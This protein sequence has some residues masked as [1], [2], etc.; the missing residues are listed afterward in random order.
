MKK[1]IS[2]LIA[3][4]VFMSNTVSS[5]ALTDTKI[6]TDSVENIYVG[7]TEGSE[8]INNL[9]YTDVISTHWAREKIIRA[10]A[11]D[12]VKAY[13]RKFYPSG[14]VSNQEAVAFVI[15]VMGLENE[16]QT[17]AVNVENE[18][19]QTA[20]VR[21][22][23][24]I[25]YLSLARQNG[26]IS[27]AEY[28]DCIN[29]NQQNLNPALNF[30]K[31]AAA[32]RERV[33][34][35]IVKGIGVLDPNFLIISNSQQSMYKYSD[36]DA[37]DVKYAQSLEILC[38]KGILNG[39]ANGRI[40]PKGNLTRAEM[41]QILS[42]LDSVYFNSAGFENKTGTVGGIQDSQL[43]QTGQASL[44]RNIYIRNADGKIDVLQYQL[45]SSSSPQAG[46]RDSVVYKNG[47][48][49]GLSSLQEGD[50]IE[51][52]VKKEPESTEGESEPVT[53][54]EIPGKTNT[55]A[56]S[57]AT[58][59]NTGGSADTN[60]PKTLYFVKVTNGLVNSRVQ[61]KLMQIDYE[62]G[63]IH[64]LDSLGKRFIYSI[65][66]GLYGKDD[67]GENYIVMGEKR[68]KDSLLPYGSSV[69]L[70]LVNNVV[71]N[72]EYV[73]DMNLQNE[74][75]GTVVENNQSFGYLTVIDNNGNEVTKNYYSEQIQVEKQQYYDTDDEVGYID[76][77]FP[78][79]KYD[80]RDTVIS[81][82]EP[83]DIVFIKTKLDDPDTIE[84][85]S[86]STNY[87]MKYGKISQF[88]VDGSGTS[89]LMMQ[90][91]NG[92]SA[93]FE[94][95]DSIFIS[96]AG[97]PINVND[98]KVGDWA[99]IL[100]NQAIITPGYVMES[101]KEMTVEGT[102]HEI[103][104]IIKGELGAINNVQNQISVQNSY[105][106]NK[107]GW[108]D[109]QQIRNV[110]IANGDIQYYYEGK[111]ISLDYAMRYL[112]HSDNDVYIALENN[113]SGEKVSMISF[114][115]SSEAVI[116]ADTVVNSDG[117]GSFNILSKDGNISTDNG[118]IVRRYGRLVT[119]Q[120][121]MVPDYATVVLNGNNKAAVVDIYEQPDISGVFIGRGRIQSVDEGN[122]FTVSSA[123]V[124]TGHK[125]V[126]T[127]VDRTF[128][129]D[130]NTIYIKQDGTLTN[131]NEFIEYSTESV[132]SDVF[133]I[134]ANGTKAT[135][136]IESPYAKHAVR[137]DVVSADG[138][139]IVIKNG[140]Y[141]KNKATS[142]DEVGYKDSSVNITVPTNC[143]IVKNNQVVGVSAIEKG[144]TVRVMTDELPEQITGGITVNG[145]IILVES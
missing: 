52:I 32:T 100:V 113:Y 17:E 131:M 54:A 97:K 96:K 30:I 145:Y 141:Y 79:F 73:G 91:E 87:T 57:G 9:K 66:D 23:W 111:Q 115:S 16:A 104:T 14:T 109:Y 71:D 65:V 46:T 122:S 53:A 11:L 63:K 19:P 138:S 117:V 6:F 76:Q 45:E 88:I 80:P 103:S 123:S 22:A 107:K 62:N 55:D 124:L 133:N 2:F 112:K 84:S 68:M 90:Y 33:A 47:Q 99:K 67:S 72:V 82:I 44:W 142:W 34:D 51:Y 106:L 139:N 101:V 83:G 58:G 102:G 24:S 13:E 37:V 128:A 108:S 26:L 81:E 40:N 126:Y 12:M 39:D 10:G 5:F 3:L 4:G 28:A 77:V 119:G 129:I 56:A 75:R 114:R 130:G 49:L 31:G 125:W 21:P 15:R 144:D 121:I 43:T 8:I 69:E 134:V 59:G 92:Q 18:V 136:V 20:G 60:N 132:V 110:S 25:G 116:D 61:G 94:V 64:I 38:A 86:A 140:S 120:S 78:N 70:S 95:P 105:V 50:E 143:V 85:I 137:G 98:V 93:S 118:T 127:P 27:D 7:R 48:V 36:W 41:A 74:I 135:H 42:N 89:Q 1:L 29:Q 35:W